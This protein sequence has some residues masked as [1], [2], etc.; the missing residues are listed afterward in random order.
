MATVYQVIPKVPGDPFP[1]QA[2]YTDSGAT[3]LV[4]GAGAT[5]MVQLLA[6]NLTSTAGYVQIFDASELPSNGAAPLVSVPIPGSGAVGLDTPIG[7]LNGIVVAISTTAETLTIST[8]N[9]K[10]YA[11]VQQA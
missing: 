4:V 8:D 11:N 1:E 2:V 10:F 9:A 6:T 3:S 5:V 7:G